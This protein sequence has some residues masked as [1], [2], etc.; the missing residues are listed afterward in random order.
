MTATG[1][2]AGARTKRWLVQGTLLLVAI[3]LLAWT[4]WGNRDQIQQVIASKP[5]PR[6]LGLAFLL[7]ML[8]MC[9]TFLRWH[10][11]VRALGL[12]FR[13]ADAFRLGLIGNVFNLVI[14]G[15]VGGDLIKAA[16][17]CREQAKKTQAVASMVIDRGVGLLGLF[18]LAG[19]AGL[20]ELP[21][22]V[23]QV[24]GLIGMAWLAVLAGV[25]GLAVLFTPALYRPLLRLVAGKGRLEAVA[26]E[27]I[28][29]ASLYRERLGVVVLALALSVLGHLLF[30]LAFT[31]VDQ[32]LFPATAPSLARHLVI[33]PLVLFTTAVP[34]PMGALGLTE[35]ASEAIFKL[36]DFPGG[37]VAMM[38][39]RVLMYVGGLLC[40]LVYLANAAQVRALRHDAEELE[41]ELEQGDLGQPGVG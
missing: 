19:V 29:L 16:F 39:Y 10:Q 1:T 36:I 30:V 17:L 4:V 7:Y 22:A 2:P 21:N 33:T 28:E 34:L 9:V 35:K 20:F 8:G 3:G 18:L 14:P 40:A 23:P 12:P 5:D 41:T 38:G 6:R 15:A 32:A 31:V 13:L 25:V 27:F 37:A 24:R 26:Q 11:L